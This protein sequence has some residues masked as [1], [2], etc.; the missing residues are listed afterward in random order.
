M[1]GIMHLC[2]IGQNGIILQN[3]ELTPIENSRY[4]SP[5]GDSKTVKAWQQDLETT[6]KKFHKGKA[7]LMWVPQ[8][9]FRS[10]SHI[11]G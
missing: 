5:I 6:N 10:I 8:N 11:S 3:L 1:K 7:H 9:E 4:Q 2:L